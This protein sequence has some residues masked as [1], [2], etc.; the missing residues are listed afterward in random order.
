MGLSPSEFRGGVTALACKKNYPL[1]ADEQIAAHERIAVS[2]GV[3]GKQL[4]LAPQDYVRAAGA[5][6][7]PTI[8]AHPR[9]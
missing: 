3:P 2:A 8:R 4:L 1:F 6:L 5:T 7:G 9:E